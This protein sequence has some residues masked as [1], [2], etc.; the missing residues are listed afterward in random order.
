VDSFVKCQV[1]SGIVKDEKILQT[2]IPNDLVRVNLLN[3]SLLRFSIPRS[4]FF[5]K[6]NLPIAV[7]LCCQGFL[8]PTSTSNF[9]QILEELAKVKSAYLL[10]WRSNLIALWINFFS[11]NLLY[12]FFRN[13]RLNST[14]LLSTKRQITTSANAYLN[15]W[16][17]QHLFFMPLVQ[18]W[19]GEVWNWVKKEST[20]KFFSIFFTAARCKVNGFSGSFELFEV[21]NGWNRPWRQRKCRC[22]KS[23]FKWE[24][25]APTEIHTQTIS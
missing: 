18:V 4:K 22:H 19:Y 5:Q 21:E 25:K 24:T 8:L 9:L 14:L 6:C 12:Y 10:I 3:F 1:T 15:W 13:S 11:H 17:N 2:S 16:P 20:L 7:S 23:F